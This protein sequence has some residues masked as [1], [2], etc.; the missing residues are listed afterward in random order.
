M[1]NGTIQAS[2][3]VRLEVGQKIDFFVIIPTK[4]L[5]LFFYL[6]FKIK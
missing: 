2:I 5:S 6:F 3:I 1:S 4:N